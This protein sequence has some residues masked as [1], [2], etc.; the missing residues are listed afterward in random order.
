M[1]YILDTS[2][3]VAFLNK[4]DHLH[5]WATEVLSKINAPLYT[6][7]AVITESLFLVRGTTGPESILEMMEEGLIEISFELKNHLKEIKNFMNKYKKE[8][9]SFAD[10]CLVKMLEQ[11][12]GSII[13]TADSDFKYYKINKNKKITGIFP[14]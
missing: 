11:N 14:K 5:K 7:E 6:C 9:V 12:K 10:A 1:K 13:L 3:L 4:D 2:V 8:K